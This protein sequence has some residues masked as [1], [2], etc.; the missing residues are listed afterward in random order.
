[1]TFNQL[2]LN[3]ITVPKKYPIN[4]AIRRAKSRAIN[5]SFVEEISVSSSPDILW[6]NTS[7][8]LQCFDRPLLRYLCRQGLVGKWEYR[9]S[10]DEPCSLDIALVLLHDYLK[11]QNQP[12]HLIGH[13]TAGLL[14][15]LYAR[16]HPERV[17]S[18]TLLAVGA[19]PAVDWQAHYY[20]QRQL[21]ECDRLWQCQQGSHFFHLFYPQT[22]G[23]VILE[24]WEAQTAPVIHSMTA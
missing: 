23:Q 1:M 6:L 5:I 21:V 16:Q 8:S 19:N 15:L 18:L 2:L 17:R 13:S 24:F 10:Q 3:A 4:L 20:I 14:G 7:P 11:S 9:Q 12:V 22:V